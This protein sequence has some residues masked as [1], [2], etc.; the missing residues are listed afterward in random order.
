MGLVEELATFI[1]AESTRFTSGTNLFGNAKPPEPNTATWII[2]YPGG[3]AIDTL[4]GDLP[5]FE[6]ARVAITCRSTS[7][8]TARANAKAA[9]VACHKIANETL[10]GVSWLRARPLQSP[11]LLERDEQNRPVF[12]F[13][14]QCLRRTTST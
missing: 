11:F 5:K 14:V 2:E 4:A 7:S 3:A 6:D 13:N 8:V 10:S 9:W 1:D 12:Q